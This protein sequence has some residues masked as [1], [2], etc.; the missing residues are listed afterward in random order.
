MDLT[1]D[2]AMQ[3]IWVEKQHPLIRVSE[4][5]C[6]AFRTDKTDTSF[7]NVTFARLAIYS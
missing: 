1:L 4:L 7:K 6:P 5:G 2:E 3:F